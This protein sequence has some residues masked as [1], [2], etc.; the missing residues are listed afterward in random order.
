MKSINII[1][2][3]TIVALTVTGCKQNE[4]KPSEIKEQGTEKSANNEGYLIVSDSRQHCDVDFNDARRFGYMIADKGLFVDFQIMGGGRGGYQYAISVARWQPDGDNINIESFKMGVGRPG[5]FKFTDTPPG[6]PMLAMT[7]APTF[8]CEQQ[9]YASMKNNIGKLVFHFSKSDSVAAMAKEIINSQGYEQLK[10]FIE[11][12]KPDNTSTSSASP[13][14]AT[15][16]DEDFNKFYKKFS[17]DLKFQQSR[18]K[19][20]LQVS[21]DDNDFTYASTSEIGG[22][23]VWTDE[24]PEAKLKTTISSNTAKA[25]YWNSQSGELNLQYEFKKL[26]GKWYLTSCYSESK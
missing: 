17:V 11:N 8:D 1:L 3:L 2:T 20:P 7:L 6:Y 25:E 13:I 24:W 22:S 18:I 23:V 16:G 9:E 4:K 15:Q 19:F 10:Q 12:Y 21:N 26:D 14:E 5:K